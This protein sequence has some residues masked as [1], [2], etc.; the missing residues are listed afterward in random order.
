MENVFLTQLSVQ[1][2][3][4]IIREEMRSVIQDERGAK[5]NT[6]EDSGY[7]N[8]QE[9]SKMIDLAVPTIYGLVHKRKIPHIKRGKKLLF[10]KKLIME[11][12]DTYRQCSANQTK[13]IVE[14]L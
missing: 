2:V 9:I 11:W 12:L 14:T 6:T 8:I 3:R 10:E 5:T 1:E 4:G 13:Q 7:K